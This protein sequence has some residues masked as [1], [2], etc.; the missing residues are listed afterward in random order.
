MDGLPRVAV[1]VVSALLL[2]LTLSS[3]ASPTPPGR[4]GVIAFVTND[5]SSG[6]SSGLAVI[7]PDGQGFR[8]LTRDER[9]YSPA[10]SPDSRW[11]AFV[12]DWQIYV[13]RANGTGLHRES[14]MG[15]YSS[16]RTSRGLGKTPA[17]R[18]TPARSGSRRAFLTRPPRTTMLPN[19]IG[20]GR[21]HVN[22]IIGS[23]GS[24]TTDATETA[25]ASA[26][27]PS[28]TAFERRGLASLHASPTATTR[29]RPADRPRGWSTIATDQHCKNWIVSGSRSCATPGMK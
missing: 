24:S 12:R 18:R 3:S 8:R 7:R 28:M 5:T 27:A 9:D 4:N 15:R 22:A 26:I 13:V 10:W 1:T 29:R 23:P 16:L 21:H 25:I 20:G 14:T 6:L 19:R 17:K 2:A 11:L